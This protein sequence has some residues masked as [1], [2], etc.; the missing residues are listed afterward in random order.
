MASV[1][2]IGTPTP[3]RLGIMKTPML[4]D[5]R[6]E[7]DTILAAGDWTGAAR[8][9]ARLWDRDSSAGAAGWIVSRYE[10]LRGHHSMLPYRWAIL[11]SFTVEPMVPFLR[12]AA[13]VRGI[14]LQVHLGEFN[15]YPQEILDPESA[16]YRFRPD[17]VVLAV[18]TRDVAPDLWR[19]YARLS[20]ADRVAAVESTIGRFRNWVCS[21]RRHSQA[22][23]ILHTLETPLPPVDGIL[24]SQSEES[25]T[26]AIRRINRELKALARQHRGIY[27][28]DY[29]DLIARHGRQTW[30]DERKWLT[31]RLPIASANLPH[32]AAY[33][34]RFLHPL[35]GK[36]A[37][38]VAVDLDNTL[39]G[40]VIGEDGINGI[41]LGQE[42]PGA[43][44]QDLQRALLD[45]TRRGILLAVCSKNNLPD[46]ME[47]LGTHPGMLLTPRDFAAMRINWND[48]AQNLRE[49]A[50]ELNIGLDSVAFF[51][52]NPVERLHIR[53]QAPEAIVI[54]LPDDPMRFAQAIRD[55]PYFERLSLSEE[56]RR[57]GELYA[58]QRER[59]EL[60]AAATSKED[61]YRS[62][63]QVAEIAPVT[64]ATLARVAQLTQKTNQFN[65]TTRRYSEQQ[66]D[67]MAACAA[68]RVWSLKVTDRYA[69]NGLVGVAIAHLE[70]DTCEIDTFL[71]SCRV[72]GRTVET[73]L[74]AYLAEDARSRG[75]RWLQGWFLP[76]KKNAPAADFYRHHGFAPAQQDGPSVLWR[77]DLHHKCPAVPEWI[78]VVRTIGTQD[79][80]PGT[81]HGF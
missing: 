72:I 64:P 58:S 13:F 36:I 79:S 52:D 80:A 4:T 41:R 67:A 31:V 49:I 8:S 57:R 68:W 63:E 74:L 19:D 48:K 59:A 62:L 38:C 15:A 7:I 1:T 33:W 9:L 11:R 42:Y 24:D 81:R 39:W 61:F 56:D 71:M 47:A 37:K 45:L 5:G 17:A 53:E 40:G 54:E 27:I 51:D 70:S 66:I 23:L 76:T 35:T 55:C 26:E 28:L 29:D 12:A 34:L 69:D 6:K 77:L 25:Q 30:G 50:A 3:N 75:A 14:D 22:A 21:F 32:L 10:K 16:L 78:R 73:A 20:Q 18:Q 46:A 2:A 60:E 44:Y 43:A 65:L